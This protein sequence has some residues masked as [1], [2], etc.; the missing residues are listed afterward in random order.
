M[1]KGDIYGVS[2][3]CGPQCT[4]SIAGGFIR[5]R[6]RLMNLRKAKYLRSNS[7]SKFSEKQIHPSVSSLVPLDYTRKK[8][9]RLCPI[10]L[11]ISQ[12]HL[13]KTALLFAVM[14]L[15]NHKL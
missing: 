5:G 1:A 14:G 12:G 15:I 13:P 4:R 9:Y 7:L 6:T 10:P 11:P 8:I 2:I 3:Y